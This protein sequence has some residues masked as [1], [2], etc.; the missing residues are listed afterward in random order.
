MSK[1]I[2]LDNGH[3][4]NTKGKCSPDGRLKEWAYTREIVRRIYGKLSDLGYDVR[5]ITPEDNDI[6]LSVRTKRVNAICDEFGRKNVLLVS[7]HTNALGYG[8]WKNASG[9]QIHTCM[10]PSNETVQL[11]NYFYNSASEQNVKTRRPSPNQNYWKND[12]WIL[13]NTKCPAVLTENF[14]HSHKGDVDFM[15]SEAGKDT[16]TNIH[17][18][19]I[20]SYI[21]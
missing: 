12:Y 1:V 16:I 4:V 11:A 5:I 2:L 7:V 13:K 10:N 18:N 15:L 19:A 3:G 14:F 8:E 9:W 6:G 17:V 20:L 21:Q